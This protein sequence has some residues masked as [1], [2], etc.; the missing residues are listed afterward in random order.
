MY[1]KYVCMLLYHWDLFENELH[2]VTTGSSAYMEGLE[3][4]MGTLFPLSFLFGNESFVFRRCSHFHVRITFFVL[5]I[6]A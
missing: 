3:I 1:L 4:G 2:L 6:K 5:I